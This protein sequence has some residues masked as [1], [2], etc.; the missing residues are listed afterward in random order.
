MEQLQDKRSVLVLENEDIAYQGVVVLKNVN[1]SIYQGEKV[2][3]IG[4][5]GAGKTTLLR[6][7]YQISPRQCAFIHQHYSLV[8][9]LTTFHNIYMGRLDTHTIFH[10]IR[11]LVLPSKIRINEIRPIAEKLGLTEKLFTRIGELSGGQQQR[12]GI[13]RAL[14]RGV[15]ILMADEPV[16]SLDAVQQAQIMDFITNTCKTVV[17]SLHSIDLSQQFF[18]RVIGLKDSKVFFDLPVDQ[19]SDSQLKALYG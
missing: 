15:S 9:Q 10:N 17:T 12:V 4:K 16:S 14:Y 1:V 3:L 13:G 18:N 7:L 11:N 2:A 8:S 5:S 19:V 6:R